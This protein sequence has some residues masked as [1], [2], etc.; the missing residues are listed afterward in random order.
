MNVQVIGRTP[1]CGGKT[2]GIAGDNL[3]E[4]VRFQLDREPDGR[5][6]IKLQPPSGDPFRSELTV[7]GTEAVW[8][9]EAAA[10]ASAGTLECQLMTENTEYTP[11]RVWQ[12]ERFS[13]NVLESLGYEKAE[14]QEV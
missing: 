4:R 11:P 7:S 10:V 1:D 13:L 14:T 12:S 6:Y 2:V 8:E 9:V 5:M 3:T